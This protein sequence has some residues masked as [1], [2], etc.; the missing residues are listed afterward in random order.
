M[1]KAILMGA[2]LAFGALTLSGCS[3]AASTLDGTVSG[4]GASV[5]QVDKNYWDLSMNYQAMVMDKKTIVL[6]AGGS[7]T[8]SCAS[9]F[10]AVE[11]VGD[12]IHLT[13]ST[14]DKNQS[15]TDDYRV[16]FFEVKTER[17]ITEETVIVIDN[18]TWGGEPRVIEPEWGVDGIPEE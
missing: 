8:K 15:C 7:G 10:T 14:G 18:D 17:P 1:K 16:T 12:D 13:Y 9:R 2:M 3:P 6:E 5:R 4:E 11:R